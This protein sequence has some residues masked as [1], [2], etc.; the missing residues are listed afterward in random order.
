[1]AAAEP[2]RFFAL[3]PADD[4]QAGFAGPNEASVAGYPPARPSTWPGRQYT[5]L[6]NVSQ[7]A[8]R[9]NSPSRNA[10]LPRCD[11]C[12]WL[13]SA[14]A[15]RLSLESRSEPTEFCVCRYLATNAKLRHVLDREGCGP[16]Y[17]YGVFPGRNERRRLQNDR[18][19]RQVASRPVG[20]YRSKTSLNPSALIS[21]ARKP[22]GTVVSLAALPGGRLAANPFR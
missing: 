8:R 5:N 14:R 17:P 22:T 20:S 13:G 19:R 21:Q 18:V 12:F 11:A 15:A 1:M 16:L 3:R 2:Y 9:R 4:E 7:A 10:Q 6:L